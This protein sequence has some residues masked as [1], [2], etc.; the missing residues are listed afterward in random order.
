MMKRFGLI[1]VAGYIAPR[2]IVAIKETNNQLIVGMDVNDS[3]GLLDSF[4]PE[5]EFFT[6]FE[7]FAAFLSDE[8]LAGRSFDFIAI[9]SPNHLHVPHIKFAISN[10][11]NV[12]CEKPLVLHAS[13]LNIISSYEKIYGAKV[14]TILQLR[15][16]PSI[17]SMR[18]KVLSSSS[19]KAFDVE[20]TYITCRGKWYAE[21][22]KGFEEKSGGVATNIG[23]HLFDMLNF[24]FGTP[25]HH[26]VHYRD[27]STISGRSHYKQATVNWFLSISRKHLPM[28]AV[29][30][31]KST[32]RS[33]TIDGEDIEFSNGF[34]DL[35]TESYVNILSG[36]G[37]GVEANKGAIETVEHVRK[38]EIVGYPNLPHSF[39]KSD[40]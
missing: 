27:L 23:I 14:N 21:S 6:E 25:L 11:V 16:H 39:L 15:L 7:M 40:A 12:I 1:G 32:Y 13:D 9:C 2:H 5:A 26:E 38:A 10:G 34:T 33:I 3:V 35:H 31:E 18:Q 19:N 20:L 4:F 29:E 17:L 24:I 8:K 30:D 28:S 37:Y 36:N 22:W